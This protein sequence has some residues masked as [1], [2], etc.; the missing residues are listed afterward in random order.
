MTIIDSQAKRDHEFESAYLQRGVKCELG[1]I[2]CRAVLPP[3]RKPPWSAP[4]ALAA[5]FAPNAD[6]ASRTIGEHGEG[7]L[8]L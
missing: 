6:A 7:P 2:K 8:P 5:A 3:A 1:S 4:G